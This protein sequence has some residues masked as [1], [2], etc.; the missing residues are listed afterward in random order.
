MNVFKNINKYKPVIKLIKKRV[1]SGA[2]RNLFFYKNFLPMHIK[3]KKLM[4]IKKNNA[5]TSSKGTRILRTRG[6]KTV[7]YRLYRINYGF[8]DLRI[9][10]IAGLIFIPFI[11]KVISIVFLSSGSVTYIISTTEHK[12]F[13]ITCLYSCFF[14]K[15]K[16]FQQALY[17]RPGYFL[18][19]SFF[20]IKQLPKNKPICLVEQTPLSNVKYIRSPGVK[21][22]IIKMDSR[23]SLSTIKLPSGKTKIFSS[24]SIGSVGN[25]FLTE[26]KKYKNT[27]AGYYKKNGFKSTVR[28]VAMNPVDH[29]HGGRAKSIKLQRTPW[30]KVTKLK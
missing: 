1:T 17:I 5:G 28:G 25:V 7:K 20:L 15:T 16:D 18:H 12:L 4:Y 22:K 24:Y 29:P 11:N 8:R 6:A 3:N 27:K 10:F 14:K 2:S 9:C 23:T 21:G 13:L 26:N 30:G 19:Q